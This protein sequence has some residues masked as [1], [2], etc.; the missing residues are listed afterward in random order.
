MDLSKAAWRKSSH[1]AENQGDCIE[2]AAV[3]GSVAVR[4]SKDPH[5]GGLLVGRAGF[6]RFAGVVKGL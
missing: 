5:G 2:L 1:S 4:D 6:R 3:P